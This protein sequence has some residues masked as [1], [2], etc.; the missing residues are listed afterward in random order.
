MIVFKIYMRL[1]RCGRDE[2]AQVKLHQG[3]KEM[4]HVTMFRGNIFVRICASVVE[5]LETLRSCPW[6][7]REVLKV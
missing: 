5:V 1:M 7:V 3:T 6:K 4:R 2:L